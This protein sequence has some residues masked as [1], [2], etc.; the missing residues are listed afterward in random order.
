[1]SDLSQ[2]TLAGFKTWITYQ[3]IPDGALPDDSP[4]IPV[5]YNVSKALV[6]QWLATVPSPDIA[7]PS[8]YA[9]TVYNLAMDRVANYAP[10][11]ENGPL[12]PGTD[13]P[14]WDGFRAATNLYGFVGGIISSASD[15]GTSQS[16]V[17]PEQMTNMTMDDLQT[18]K[19]RW[20]RTYMGFA[21]MFGVD[22]GIS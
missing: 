3:G 12:Y 15:N 4:V 10:N 21:Q 17:T 11:P 16:M 14:Y 19:T 6:N 22:W 13:L 1:M 2:P 18:L 20:G 7:L 9:L 5:A 8:I